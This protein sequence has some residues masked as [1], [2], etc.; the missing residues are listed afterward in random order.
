M[1]WSMDSFLDLDLPDTCVRSVNT[2]MTIIGCILMHT[3]CMVHNEPHVHF[4]TGA[5]SRS[6]LTLICRPYELLQHVFRELI[7]RFNYSDMM[8]VEMYTVLEQ[9]LR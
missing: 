1:S 2:S 9:H 5:R 6:N 7:F 3:A 8:T 4:E